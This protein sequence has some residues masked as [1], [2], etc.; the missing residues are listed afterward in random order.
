MRPGRGQGTRHHPSGAVG[1]RS[2]SAACT[3]AM[4][5]G[6]LPARRRPVAA[7]I[8]VHN[9][10]SLSVMDAT[11]IQPLTRRADERRTPRRRSDVRLRRHR[12]HRRADGGCAR[13]ARPTLGRPRHVLPQGLHPPH[14]AVPRRMPLLHLREDPGWRRAPYLTVDDGDRDRAPRRCS[15]LHGG[16]VHAG[17]SARAAVPGGAR[18]AGGDGLR[19][20]HRLPG[21]C[22]AAGATRRPASCPRQPRRDAAR[23]AGPAARS[24]GVG[25]DHARIGVPA[26]VREG[27]PHYGSPDKDPAVRLATLEH[28]GG[29]AVP[30]TTGILIG[31]G[32]TRRER[33]ESL[34]RHPRPSPTA[35]G[36]SRK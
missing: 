6:V 33:I 26:A 8:P 16:A 22:R 4:S 35:T 31:I 30:F 3:A 1:E 27:G 2:A 19:V 13:S 23:R 15:R 24:L 28:A 29:L 20:H 7:L 11:T 12:R 18:S 25:G 17:G 21:P 36:T 10:A 32:E 5:W 14:R 34:A 9:P